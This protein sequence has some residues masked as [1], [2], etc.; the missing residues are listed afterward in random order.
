MRKITRDQRILNISHMDF[1]GVVSQILLG[2]IFPNI[3]YITTSFGKVDGHIKNVDY[4]KW[5]HVF[6]TDIYPDDRNLLNISDKIILIDHHDTTGNVS[7]MS[8]MHF[9]DKSKCA[10]ATVKPWLE[11][12]F[13]VRMPYLNDL[14]RLTN[15]YD[16][17]QL[18]YPESKMIAE[19]FWYYKP[20]GFRNRFFSGNVTLNSQELAYISLKAEEYKKVYQNLD[21]VDFETI[22]GCLIFGVNDFVNDICHDLMNKDGYKIVFMMTKANRIS[23]RH[24]IQGLHIGNMLM[25]HGVGGGHEHAAGMLCSMDTKEMTFQVNKITNDIYEHFPDSRRLVDKPIPF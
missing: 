22:N 12:Y 13:N 6:L 16:M 8:K 1:D 25:K 7:N 4:S 10:A 23:I 18:Q 20:D 14:V 3:Y 9:V 24:N 2:N 21:G 19:L 5:D 17:W 15:D 11:T